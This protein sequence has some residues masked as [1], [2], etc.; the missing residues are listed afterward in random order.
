MCVQPHDTQTQTQQCTE[1]TQHTVSIRDQGKEGAL[2]HTAS[3]M[4]NQH[5]PPPHKPPNPQTTQTNS[6]LWLLYTQAHNQS[7]TPHLDL[8]DNLESNLSWHL[9]PAGG[10][11]VTEHTDNTQKTHR[12][13]HAH[14]EE[15]VRTDT[16]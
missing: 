11:L 16:K 6:Q 7:A 1:A 12:H 2:R 15:R 3:N 5:P 4:G 14:T 10:V 9:V 8:A 13:T